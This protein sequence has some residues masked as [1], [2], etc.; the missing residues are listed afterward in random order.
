MSETNK[1]SEPLIIKTNQPHS[2]TMPEGTNV[3]VA[4]RGRKERLLF[5]KS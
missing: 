4:K 1:P 2:V 3:A 5:A